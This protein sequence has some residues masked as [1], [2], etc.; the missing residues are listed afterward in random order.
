VYPEV[1]KTSYAL[2]RLCAETWGRPLV[3][4]G[5]PGPAGRQRTQFPALDQ[6][7]EKT[8]YAVIRIDGDIDSTQF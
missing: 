4:A 2:R 7:A 5:P 8:R 3:C 6:N 1:E